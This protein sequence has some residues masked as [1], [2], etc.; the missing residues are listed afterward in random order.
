MSTAAWIAIS[1]VTTALAAALFFLLTRAR[2]TPYVEL[3]PD[4]YPQLKDALPLI[5]GL[6][7]SC[8]YE[9]NGATVL[10]NGA[11]YPAML[12]DIAAAKH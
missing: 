5:A 6:T 8:V 1:S 9:G 11:I 12:N 4:E 2:G 3:N 7:E 10:Q